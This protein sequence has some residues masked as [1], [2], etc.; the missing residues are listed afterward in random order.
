[1]WLVGGMRRCRGWGLSWGDGGR[2]GAGGEGVGFEGLRVRGVEGLRSRLGRW[3]FGGIYIC[4]YA[5]VDY[6][7]VLGLRAYGQGDFFASMRRV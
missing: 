2:G 5:Y 6:N 1:M 4:M 3:R 7:N